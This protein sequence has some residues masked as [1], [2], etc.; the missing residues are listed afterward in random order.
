MPRPG[1]SEAMRGATHPCC[2]AGTQPVRLA[3]SALTSSP[4]RGRGG[5]EQ[6]VDPAAQLR[7]GQFADA[8]PLERPAGEDVGEG[9][10]EA[11]AVEAGNRPVA[12]E[13]DGHRPAPLPD[14][15][16][17]GVAVV[18]DVQREETHPPTVAP[19]GLV[20][21]VLLLDAATAFGEPER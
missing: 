8:G 6:L 20:D 5:G 14:Q 11:D 19:E 9:G 4:F 3:G 1:N 13:T 18:A 2:G 15:V 10:T 17:E 21:Q 7:G 12:V 16:A